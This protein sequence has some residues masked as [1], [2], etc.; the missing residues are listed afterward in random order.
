MFFQNKK[1]IPGGIREMT[2]IALPMI[3]SSACDTIMIFTDRLF[4]ARLG[5]QEMNAAMGGGLTSFMMMSLFLGLVGYSTALVAQYFGAGQKGKSAVVVTQAMILCCVAYPVILLCRPLGW[6]LFEVFDI[7]LS[8][9][10]MQKMYFDI[11]LWAS[12]LGL[13]RCAMSSFFSGIGRTRIVMIA[14]VTAMVVNVILNYILIYGKLGCPPLGIRGA[15]YGTIIGSFCGLMVL[16]LKYFDRKNR[17]E[18]ATTKAFYFDGQI[19]KKLLRFG[20]PAGL[21]MF[22]NI[23]A[24]NLM[25]MIFYS[26]G[27]VV[28]TATTIVFNWDM[29]S[30]IPLLGVEIGVTSLVGRY[31]GAGRPDIAERAVGSG[32]K[33]GIAY[34]SVLFILFVGFPQFLVNI[35]QP[36]QPSAVFAQAFPVAVFMVRLACLYVLIEAMMV[37]LTGA[38]RGAGDSFWAMALSVGLHWTLVPVIYFLLKVVGVSA[39]VGWIVLIATFFVFSFLIY[40]RY[41]SGHWKK[42][43][44]VP[45]E[46]EVLG[47]PRDDFHEPVDL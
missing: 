2:S 27:P 1:T 26:C 28:A 4:L 37:A 36:A 41:K 39:Q 38:L 8:Q 29:V 47:L 32:I 40:L 13:L 7:E 44:M 24:F 45:A 12:L 30:F 3:I 22:L 35:F 46:H 34:S 19:M 43:K 5:S 16:L 33:M 42:I 20:Y 11:L 21:E 9:F 15:A 14:S 23:L 17:C 31:M 18:Y 25:V 6:K 10:V